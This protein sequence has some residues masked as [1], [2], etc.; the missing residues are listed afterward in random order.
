[1]TFEQWWTE[2]GITTPK[3]GLSYFSAE[4]AWNAQQRRLDIAIEALEY[5]E[6]NYDYDEDYERAKT[7]L[8]RI[9]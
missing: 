7:A 6:A 9:K 5:F 4:M 1:M 2:S 8:K 3:T